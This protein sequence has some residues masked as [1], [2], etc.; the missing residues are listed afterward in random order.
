[1][2]MV[3][4][5]LLE[6]LD[7]TGRHLGLVSRGRVHAEGLW[8]RAAHVWL[9][10]AEGGIYIQRRSVT[11]DLNPDRWDVSVGEHLQP[12]EDYADAAERGLRE[13]LGLSGCRLTP[14]GGARGVCVDHPALGIHDRE[15]Q[16]AFMALAPSVPEPDSREV[17]AVELVAA[18]SL[19]RWLRASPEAFTPGLHRDV[20]DLAVL[21][22]A[23]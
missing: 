15:F 16:Q 1:M 7:E 21:S 10:D 13:E 23:P 22:E 8:H 14:I 3:S 18:E 11:K 9:F 6:A 5:E 2:S 4:D 20:A 19:R 17:A 12:G